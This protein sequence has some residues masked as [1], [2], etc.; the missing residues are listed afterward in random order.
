MARTIH[1]RMHHLS[2]KQE[3]HTPTPNPT[4]QNTSTRQCTTIHTDCNGPHHRT[5][6]KQGIRQYPYNSQPRMHLR[7]NIPTLHYEHHQTPNCAVILPTRVPLVWTPPENNHRLRPPI[8][9]TFRQSPRKRTGNYVEPYN[10]LS[11]PNQWTIRKEESMGR[12]IP[13]PHRHQSRRLGSGPS[14]GHVST[15]QRKEHHHRVCSK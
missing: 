4:I 12:T 3:P 1:Q 9:I 14:P 5:T 8:H 7:R 13:L 11:P 6:Q 2:T 15:Q 10:S